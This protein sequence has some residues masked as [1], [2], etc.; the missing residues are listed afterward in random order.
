MSYDK[1]VD[2]AALDAVFSGIG[3]A[4]REKSETT[5]S[6]PHTEMGNAIRN[7]SI[8]EDL[9]AEVMAQ[10]AMVANI[11]ESLVG[12]ATGANATPETILEGYSAYVGQKLIEGIAS[13]GIDIAAMF[14]CS[15]YA[16]DEVTFSSRTEWNG[17]TISHSLS[18]K[19]KAF[20]LV[21][22]SVEK[23]NGD[24]HAGICVDSENSGSPFMASLT[25]RYNLL[26]DANSSGLSTT[27][28]SLTDSYIETKAGSSTYSY[29]TAGMKYYVITMA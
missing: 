19:P 25:W 16:V 13:A 1:V 8:G 27:I 11:I 5:A 12:K 2:S 3:D 22:E 26:V 21:A 6:I 4:I 10:P 15:K 24:I 23:T 14:G 29:L 20:I 17:A 7:L 28:K 9:T 18:E